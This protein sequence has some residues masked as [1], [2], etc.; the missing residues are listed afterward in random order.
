[1]RFFLSAALVL[2]A[3]LPCSCQAIDFA[4]QPWPAKWIHVPNASPSDYG[5]YH[6]RR[7]F[8][9]D[10]SPEKFVV[11]VSADNRYELFVNGH[12]LSWGPARSDLYHW[13]Y[14]IVDIAKQLH[15]GLNVLAAVVWNDGDLRAVAQV[16]NQTG[17]LLQA[18]APENAQVNTNIDWKCIRDAAYSP[19]PW[20]A[21]QVTGYH[22]VGANE[23]L[24]GSLYPWGWESLEFDDSSWGRAAEISTAFPRDARDAP[25]RWMLTP[26]YIPLEEQSVER[27]R[28]LRSSDGV[29]AP[30]GFPLEQHFFLIPA[31]TRATMLLDQTYLTTAYPELTV[32]GGKGAA[33]TLR[34]AETLYDKPAPGDHYPRKSN[35]NEISGKVFYGTADIFVPDG[36]TNRTYRPLFWRT[37]R[38]LELVIST[39]D[40]PL[41]LEDIH[42]VFTSYPFERNARITVSDPA[43]NEEIQQ[44]LA[45]GW[46][47]ARLCAHETYMDCPYYEQ[48]QYAGDARIQM[49]ISLYTSG[50]PRLM[51]NGIELLNSSRTAEGA[52]YSRAPSR[53]EQ[54]IPPFSLLWIGIV[55]DYWMYV[56]D[57]PF[58]RTML[59]GVQAVLS[60]FAAHQ[61]PSGSLLRM[62]WWNFVDWTKHWND[63]VAP[64]EP[65]G[66]S[67]AALDLQLLF[68]YRWAAE[69]E[70]SL[71]SHA[72]ADEYSSAAAKLK[73][74]ILATDWDASRG[75]FADQPSKRTYSQ[76]V[77][78][79]AM[80]AHLAPAG[81]AR[82]IVEKMFSDPAMEQSSIYFRAY[83]NATLREVGLGSRYLDSLGPWREMLKDGLTTWSEWNGPDTRSDCHAWGASPNFEIFRT[84]VGIDSSAPGFRA[85]RIA[86]NIGTLK[87]V[88]AA[89]PHPKGQITV[90]YD[91]ARHFTAD[92]TLPEGITG[93]FVWRGSSKRL[94]PGKNHLT[95]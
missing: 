4:N 80:L 63:G 65:D 76:Q 49:L 77:N 72:L 93:E 90:E 83:T 62:P 23:K 95:W 1:M 26:R 68:A 47:T 50:D 28:E 12:R 40:A 27:I 86:P 21:D 20:P 8:S 89:M 87:H 7:Q 5:V 22:A 94:H 57:E 58:V 38:Y 88:S 92:V 30:A 15:S 25:N 17:F 41:T 81:D 10:I 78:T 14:E 52:T 9:L 71:G 46:R 18:E 70:H 42:G 6:F 2:L 35:R 33:I 48:L 75:L 91:N 53:L 69:L 43:V 84:L 82:S 59:P 19:A 32:S 54:Y 73:M 44:M 64:A 85:V 67:S 74:A 34:Y 29:T 79:L 66:S 36:A 60:F 11:Y 56:D 61:K 45:T 55:H 16:S 13:R 3:S 39:Q 37:Y 31:H 51:R 24:D